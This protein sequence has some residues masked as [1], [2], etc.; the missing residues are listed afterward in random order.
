MT[1]EF[2][3]VCSPFDFAQGNASRESM[4]KKESPVMSVCET[5]S[6]KQAILRHD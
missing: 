6:A 3:N 2:L 5:N 4:L 1:E